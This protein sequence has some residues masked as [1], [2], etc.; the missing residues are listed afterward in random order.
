MGIVISRKD[1]FD[2]SKID[3]RFERWDDNGIAEVSVFNGTKQQVSVLSEEERVGDSAMPVWLLI[4]VQPGQTNRV[5][6]PRASPPTLN[7]Y[8]YPWTA[9][10]ASEAEEKT[11]NYPKMIREWITGRYNPWD[12]NDRYTVTLPPLPQV[13]Y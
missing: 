9:Q 11:R 7:V 4:Q 3:V 1:R 13:E 6:F 10:A 5:R 8:V 2:R 12:P